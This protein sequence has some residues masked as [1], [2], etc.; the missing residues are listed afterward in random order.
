MISVISPSYNCSKFIM[1]SYNC[2]LL[3][4][5]K[6]WEWIVVDD[7]SND[8]TTSVVTKII[9]TDHRVKLYTL[10]ENKGRGYA[11][12]YA[13]LQAEGDIICIWDIDDLYSPNRLELINF[14]LSDT[15]NDFFCSYALILDNKLNL[16]SARHFNR[17]VTLS[18]SFVHPSLAFKASLTKNVGYN[19]EMRAGE[20]LEVMLIL[21]NNYNGYYCEEY[22]LFYVEDREINLE[23]TIVS[24]KNQL[25]SLKKITSNGKFFSSYSDKFIFFALRYFKL[26]VLYSLKLTPNLYLKT[27]KLRYSDYVDLKKL[28]IN[29]LNIIKELSND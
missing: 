12:N 25:T 1:R 17:K 20:D 22:L 3:Q 8:N 26:I 2:L 13:I 5:Y 15:S 14:H 4:S 18:P 29:H 11:R 23:K 10:P 28:S 27:V 21:E 16:K 6:D 19:P 24:F 7:G 9:E